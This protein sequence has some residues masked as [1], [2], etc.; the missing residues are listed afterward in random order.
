MKDTT[1]LKTLS[2]TLTDTLPYEY[3]EKLITS[4][5][6]IVITKEDSD[7]AMY[8][9]PDAPDTDTLVGLVSHDNQDNG[10]HDEYETFYWPPEDEQ[11]PLNTI[12]NDIKHYL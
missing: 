7:R 5:N 3:N 6:T 2:K 10:H 11:I 4:E 9:S 12:L 1:T 8:I